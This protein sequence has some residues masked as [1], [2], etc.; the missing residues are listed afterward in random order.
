MRRLFPLALNSVAVAPKETNVRAGNGP[1][2]MI[3]IV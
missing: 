3:Y 2:F 1:N